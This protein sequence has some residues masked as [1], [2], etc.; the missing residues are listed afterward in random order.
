MALFAMAAVAQAQVGQGAVPTLLSCTIND[1]LSA[2]VSLDR[3]GTPLSAGVVATSGTHE[4]NVQ[5]QGAASADGE[6]V[7]RF[8]WTD[9]V[10]GNTRYQ[11]ALKR[12]DG[13]GYSLALQP[14]GCGTLALPATITLSAQSK[15]CKTQ[16]DRDE[17]FVI[18]WQQLRDAITRRDG[19]QL[20]RLSLPQ[21][22]FSEGS[23]DVKAPAAVIR[24]AATCIPIVPTTESGTDIG[25]LLKSITTPRLDQPPL[26]R[27][28]ADR[29]SAGNA[30]IARWTAQGWRLEWFNASRSVF[31]GCRSG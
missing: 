1:G 30:F 14:A 3:A 23:D 17:A 29:A 10:E 16:V 28:G 13:G 25:G 19:E 15:T 6:G 22:L 8:A 20:Q 7:W 21:L 5:T 27:V 18:F 24:N 4:C 12:L 31:S 9:A 26:S 2:H 11:A